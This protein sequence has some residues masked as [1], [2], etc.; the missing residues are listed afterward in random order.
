MTIN[1][2]SNFDSSMPVRFYAKALRVYPQSFRI[3]YGDEM[4]ELF[5]VRWERRIDRIDRTQYQVRLLIK[6]ASDLLATAPL[7][8]LEAIGS[9]LKPGSESDRRRRNGRLGYL[10]VAVLFALVGGIVLG[11]APQIF[12]SLMGLAQAP[13]QSVAD[14][15]IAFWT[16]VGMTRVLGAFLMICSTVPLACS[17]TL[18]RVLRRGLVSGLVAASMAGGAWI[19]WSQQVTVWGTVMGLTIFGGFCVAGL[20]ALALTIF[21]VRRPPIVEAMA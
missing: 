4:L 8:R 6:T 3:R 2:P 12:A 21:F 5:Q 13:A 11:Y 9:S 20:M 1:N 7:E 16:G 15:N 19:V 10:S 17:M 18:D 14:P